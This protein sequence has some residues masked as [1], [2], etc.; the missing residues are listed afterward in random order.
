MLKGFFHLLKKDF[1]LMVSGKFFLLALASLLLYSCYINFVYVNLDQDIY[2]VCLYDPQSKQ[3]LI[4]EYVTKVDTREALETACSDRYSIGFDLSGESPELYML[5]SGSDV[6]DHYRSIWGE[7]V[8]AGNTD[9]QAR[10]IG[11]NNKEMK[12]RREIT[13]EFLFFE[14]SAVGFLGLASMLF[15]EKQMGVIRVHGILPVSKSMFI[16]S[17]LFLLFISDLTFAALLTVLNVGLSHGLAVLPAVLVHAGILSLIMALIGFFCAVRL[18]NFKQFS[19]VYLALAVFVTTPVFM[20]GQIGVAWDWIVYHPMYH[21]FMAMKSAYFA[22]PSAGTI[23]Y[24]ISFGAI[25]LL[26]L[27]AHRTLT[28]EI[29]KEG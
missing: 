2:P 29:T 27:L 20:A 6:T 19:L 22:A 16:L 3:P 13:A 1:R 24:L 28:I 14:L 26:F 18:P 12:N 23:Y 9:G 4:S 10:L 21:L 8:L 5:S 11:T 7:T 25:A 17:K 15:K